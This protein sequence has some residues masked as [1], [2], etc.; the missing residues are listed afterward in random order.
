SSGATLD[1]LRAN[2]PQL[3][4]TAGH[5]L[6]PL[7][8]RLG[9][10]GFHIWTRAQAMARR[11]CTAPEVPV[12]PPHGRRVA[13]SVA[14]LGSTSGSAGIDAIDHAALGYDPG[15]VVRF[16]YAG[17]RTPGSGENLAAIPATEHA[18]SDTQADLRHSAA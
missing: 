12:S 18:R 5:Y 3:L 8:I 11:P 16:S 15:D 10:T 2:G 1:W 4:R 7:P 9:R 6:E 17:G 13:V 14:G